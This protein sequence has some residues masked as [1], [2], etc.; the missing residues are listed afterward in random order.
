MRRP[1]ATRVVTVRLVAGGGGGVVRVRVSAA[2]PVREAPAPSARPAAEEP[3]DDPNA[4]P[5]VTQLVFIVHG[6]GRHDDF[7][8][9]KSTKWDGSTGLRLGGNLEFRRTLR[10]LLDDHFAELPVHVEVRAIEWHSRL[11]ARG[12]NELFCALTTMPAGGA[13]DMRHFA[14]EYLMDVLY[15]V[16]PHYGQ[17]ILDE[18]AAQLNGRYADFMREHP[19]FRGGVSIVG[20]SLGSMIVY[21]LLGTRCLA[22]RL[23]TARS[24]H[25]RALPHVRHYLE[26][27]PSPDRSPPDPNFEKTLGSS[28]L[29]RAHGYRPHRQG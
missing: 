4:P 6:I 1:A 23:P 27:R 5:R 9:E 24:R 13:S 8:E 20:H 18:V 29:C 22:V 21:D 25:Q 7:D 15:Y 14:G 10:R 28:D 17:L 12:L 11:R 26:I 19:S 16:Q 2:A 3:R